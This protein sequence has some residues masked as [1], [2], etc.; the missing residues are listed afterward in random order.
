MTFSDPIADLITSIKN[1]GAVGNPSTTVPYSRM[2]MDVAEVLKK[3]GYITG[4]EKHELP[5]QSFLC[6]LQ[7]ALSQYLL[8]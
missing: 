7:Q 6:R 5:Y 2:K 3:E 8:F 1:A 4:V